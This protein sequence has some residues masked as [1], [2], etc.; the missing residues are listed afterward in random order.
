METDFISR[1][2]EEIDDIRDRLLKQSVVVDG[3]AGN[4]LRKEQAILRNLVIRL[5]G[6]E[7]TLR[8]IKEQARWL[9]GQCRTIPSKQQ[10]SRNL[11][12]RRR[13]HRRGLLRRQVRNRG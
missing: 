10:T 11:L 8:K 2:V 7:L 13:H 12:H 3:A 9:I 1:L 5:E 6:L 4:V